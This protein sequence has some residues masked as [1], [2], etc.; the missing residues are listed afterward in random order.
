[1]VDNMAHARDGGLIK[2]YGVLSWIILR[3]YAFAFFAV[4]YVMVKWM[5][6]EHPYLSE[7]TFGID[8]HRAIAITGVI[9]LFLLLPPLTPGFMR[10]PRSIFAGVM[11][12][13]VIGAI[14]YY[15]YLMMNV[16]LPTGF[17]AHGKELLEL[18]PQVLKAV[19]GTAISGAILVSFA[20]Q[21]TRSKAR[22]QGLS[23]NAV[24]PQEL[25]AMRQARMG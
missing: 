4:T 18:G 1:M 20:Q 15:L 16:I 9:G 19:A 6:G 14:S 22:A 13:A 5:E 11:K 25:R 21:L 24:P 23:P 17:V 12:A 3:A 7:L 2:T 8:T 10:T